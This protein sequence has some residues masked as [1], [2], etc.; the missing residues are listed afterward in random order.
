MP[1]AVPDVAGDAGLLQTGLDLDRVSNRPLLPSRGKTGSEACR[2][3]RRTDSRAATA[4]EFRWTAR[5]R[6]VLG[7]REF[8]RSAIKMHL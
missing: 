4:S 8:N 2:F 1:V 5:G 6:A 3:G 7:F